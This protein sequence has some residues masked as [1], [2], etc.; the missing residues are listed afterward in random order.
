MKIPGF[1]LVGVL[2]ASAFCSYASEKDAEK[3][4]L[5]MKHTAGWTSEVLAEF[6]VN[7]NGTFLYEA[8]KVVLKGSIPQA[9]IRAIL[10]QIEA[11]GVGP[12]AKDAGDVQLKWIAKDKSIVT[13]DYSDPKKE[14]CN[15]LLGKIKVLAKKYNK[16]SAEQS[17]GG[18]VQKAASQE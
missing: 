15:E 5:H 14:P 13:K 7:K 6:T 4:V 12:T 18:D 11:A 16:Q 10:K 9:E 1:I 8:K 3:R 2:T 17:P